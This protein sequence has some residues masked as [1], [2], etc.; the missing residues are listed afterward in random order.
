MLQRGQGQLVPYMLAAVA[1][2]AYWRHRRSSDGSLEL[3]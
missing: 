2:L 3:S 1:L